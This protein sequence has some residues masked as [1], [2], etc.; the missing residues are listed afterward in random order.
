[1]TVDG[2][3]TTYNGN[4]DVEYRWR[5]GCFSTTTGFPSRVGFHDRRLVFGRTEAQPD[6]FWMSKTSDW[7]LFSPTEYDLVNAGVLDDNAIY[8]SLDA[9]GVDAIEWMVSASSFFIG[10]T[11]AEWIVRASTRGE[12]VTPETVNS[13]RQTFFGG[14]DV[15]AIAVRNSVFYVQRTGR[16]LMEFFFDVQ[17]DYDS[18]DR[19][20][21]NP[22]ILSNGGEALDIVYQQ[23]PASQLHV[24]R[25]DGQIASLTFNRKQELFAWSRM[26]LGGSFGT[27]AHGVIESI[28]VVPSADGRSNTLYMVVK[29]TI[30]GVTK[31]YNEFLKA[32]FNPSSATDKDDMWFVDSGLSFENVA[33]TSGA[34]TANSWYRVTAVGT[35]M[36]LSGVGGSATPAI[37]DEF[38]A[39]FTV[40]TSGT[41]TSGV[42]YRVTNA[43]GG[44]MNLANVGG[45]NPALLND[46]FTA[47]ST[48]TP[49]DYDGGSL[50]PVPIYGTGGAL[51]EI[52]NSF[53]V[54]H[55]EGE[56]CDVL[57]DL[58]VQPQKVV[59][60]G[61]I[62][63]DDRHAK[64][65]IGL[66]YTPDMVTLPLNQGNPK[67]TAQ[68]RKKRIDH[69]GIRRLNS[70]GGTITAYNDGREIDEQP[71][72]EVRAGMN[73][74]PDLK[75]DY[76]EVSIEQAIA[77]D[78]QIRIRQTQPYPLTVTNLVMEA[79][80]ME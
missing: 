62:T 23:F 60:S 19:S 18:I 78:A 40:L 41:V 8:Y 53:S 51:V 65:L 70:L 24:L 13:V 75:S 45:N 67:G 76:N 30:N 4:D 50:T 37:K 61:V 12:A 80:V 10:T 15:D 72:Q 52:T 17:S 39:V 63:T 74:S 3:G 46:E 34:L 25:S 7:E 71:I 16:K 32:D 66:P 38:K 43:G 31:R 49:T 27:T 9:G 33:F 1:M 54:P 29:R 73:N 57:G 20:I 42:R 56:T 26:L 35:G 5:L 58:A 22:E 36:D 69:V 6:T 48:A 44:N 68:G 11:G 64:A 59:T 2:L 28:A 79:K 77:E 47:T 14:A 21:L 55:L